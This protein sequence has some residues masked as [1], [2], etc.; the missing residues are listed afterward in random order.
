MSNM[1]I[2]NNQF[3]VL[4][5]IEREQKRTPGI[6]EI[7]AETKLPAELVKGICRDFLSEGIAVK[8]SEGGFSVT[9][10]GLAL[11]EPYRVKRAVILAAG[12]GSRMVPI[13][14]NTPKPLVRVHG[15][16]IIETLLDAIKAA[17]IEEVVLIRGY[18]WEQFDQ[19]KY[20]YPNI[21]FIENHIY[22]KA[23]NISSAL[24]A[25]DLLCN[26]YVCEA[27]LLVSNPNLI[28]KYE[29]RSNYLGQYKD[30]TDDWCFKVENGVIREL[31]VGSENCYHMYGISYWTEED[32]KKMS[33]DIEKVYNMPKGT[34]KYWD[35]V[36]LRFCMDNYK[37]YVRPCFE[38]DIV[39][40]DTFQELQ[41]IDPAYSCD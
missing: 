4:V 22:N 38:G 21:R 40:I 12:F 8:N 1:S 6:G 30:Y 35:E 20:R 18:L 29:Y 33:S 10:K 7:A 27:D 39:E 23:N 36:A 24:F 19:L 25:K 5:Y 26:A 13:T 11:L 17:G 16:M 31:L 37:I 15:K 3:E 9:E 41:A 2:T 32:G 28:R 14:L 34:E